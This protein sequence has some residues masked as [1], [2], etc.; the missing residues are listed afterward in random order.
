MESEDSFSEIIGK[1]IMELLLNLAPPHRCKL[2]S[3]YQLSLCSYLHCKI[4]KQRCAI[5]IITA[6][7]D[8]ELAVNNDCIYIYPRA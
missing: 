5:P 4:R 1:S 2:L 7:I 3:I 8:S 6:A